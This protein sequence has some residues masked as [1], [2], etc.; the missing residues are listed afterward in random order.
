[1]NAFRSVQLCFVL[2]IGVFALMACTNRHIHNPPAEPAGQ[3][4]PLE[5]VA[6]GGGDYGGGDLRLEPVDLRIIKKAMIRADKLMPYYFRFIE[7]AVF[8][9]DDDS[10]ESGTFATINSEFMKD[11]D[12]VHFKA[13]LKKLFSKK[14]DVY[15]AISLNKLIVKEDGKC[16]SIHGVAKDG[17][18][19]VQGEIC[20]DS[21]RI[22]AKVKDV[23]AYS[24]IVGLLAHEYAHKVGA[25]E[26][27]SQVIQMFFAL[28]VKT[29]I[30]RGE[31]KNIRIKIS[32]AIDYVKWKI[33]GFEDIE[34]DIS[35]EQICKQ[36]EDLYIESES[37]RTEMYRQAGFTLSLI[38]AK[39]NFTQVVYTFNLMFLRGFYCG[40]AD[41]ESVLGAW[42]TEKGQ[43]QD[44]MANAG[45]FYNFDSGYRIY[46]IDPTDKGSL[47]K[48]LKELQRFYTNMLKEIPDPETLK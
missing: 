29:D 2:A 11:E 16:L 48:N 46:N 26:K 20:M 43:S 42:P 34:G 5:Q 12:D 40:P 31:V 38:K 9:S 39:T 13:L 3:A 33:Q 18:A 17:S 24:S 47:I 4:P 25:S 30:P 1:M 44:V 37:V 10:D 27:E 22:Q 19:T 15:S 41:L 28:H 7:F 45:S 8:S 35:T 23:H 36:F 32:N 14:N 6:Q 21:Q